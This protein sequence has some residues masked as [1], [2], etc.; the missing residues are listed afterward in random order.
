MKDL[1]NIPPLSVSRGGGSRVTAEANGVT[2][3]VH[4]NGVSKKRLMIIIGVDVIKNTGFMP[5]GKVTLHT[6]ADDRGE[7]FSLR[8]CAH[9]TACA[10]NLHEVTRKNSPS[11]LLVGLTLSAE[12]R[13]LIRFNPL[14]T[15]PYTAEVLSTSPGQLDVY[16]PVLVTAPAVAP[17]PAPRPAPRPAPMPGR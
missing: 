14:D 11:R 13:N 2:L 10:Y 4:N 1:T 5:K 3:A 8:M 6:W 16:I 7:G 12:V 17:A 9:D 15:K